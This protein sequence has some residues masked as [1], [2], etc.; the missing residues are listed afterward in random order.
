MN[1][2]AR[3]ILPLLLACFW[4]YMT[5][6]AFSNHDVIRAMVYAAI[7]TALTVWRLRRAMA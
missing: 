7:G 1:L 3:M 6:S 4:I 5:Y 2:N